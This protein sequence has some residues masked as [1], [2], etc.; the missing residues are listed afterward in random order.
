MIRVLVVDDHAVVREGLKRIFAETPDISVEGEAGDGR[1]ALERVGT[2]HYDVVVLDISM[3]GMS[4]LD[5]LKQLKSLKPELPVLMLSI[6]PEE[7]YGARTLVAGASGFL[8]KE[9]APDELISAVR[10]VSTGM[11]YVSK[12]LAEKLLDAATNKENKTLHRNF[13]NREFQV[14]CMIADGKSVKEIA[15]ALSLSP[16]TVASHRSRVLHLTGLKNDADLIRYAI[17]HGLVTPDVEV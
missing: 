4:G 13:S 1:T 2:G 15:E 12:T 11:K 17:R 7:Q 5:L 3:P 14:L 10:R 16:K 8:T 9:S 6:H